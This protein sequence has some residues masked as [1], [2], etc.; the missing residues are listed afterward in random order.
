M[1]MTQES[2]ESNELNHWTEVRIKRGVKRT[3]KEISRQEDF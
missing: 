3:T 1:G 2:A